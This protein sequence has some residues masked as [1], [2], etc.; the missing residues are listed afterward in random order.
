MTSKLAFVT[1]YYTDETWV[2]HDATYYLYKAYVNGEEALVAYE[3]PLPESY[4]KVYASSYVL[5]QAETHDQLPIYMATQVAMPSDGYDFVIK[6]N[7]LTW[8]NGDDFFGANDMAADAKIV[9]VTDRTPV[10]GAVSTVVL[11]NYDD[12]VDYLGAHGWANTSTYGWYDVDDNGDV[13][14]LYLY[15]KA[16]K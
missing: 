9:I 6:G 2:G 15:V 5:I 11:D 13:N 3:H 14:L 8:K 1:S 10:G 12:L 16:V 7:E 4:M